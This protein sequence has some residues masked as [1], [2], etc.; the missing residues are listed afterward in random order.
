MPANLPRPPGQPPLFA[1]RPPDARRAPPRR[2]RRTRLRPLRGDVSPP[3]APRGASGRRRIRAACDPAVA[4]V[5]GRAFKRC[6]LQGLR[7]EAGRRSGAA[8]A[9]DWGSASRVTCRPSA[10]TRHAAV[11]A[12]GM[13]SRRSY[14]PGAPASATCQRGELAAAGITRSKDAYRAH[15]CWR[16]SRR[17]RH[18]GAS[19]GGLRAAG[20]CGPRPPLWLANELVCQ[21]A[22]ASYLFLL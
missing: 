2:A 3:R 9:R 13:R 18:G 19:A 22:L 6:W 20:A 11:I 7:S 17:R 4:S 15:H 10:T 8:R 1:N 16:S 5:D 21:H 14:A 12:P